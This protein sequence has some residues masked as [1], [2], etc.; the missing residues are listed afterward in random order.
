MGHIGWAV[1][2]GMNVQ[3]DLPVS[4]E[5]RTLVYTRVCLSICLEMNRRLN[6]SIPTP[7]VTPQS[8]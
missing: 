6:G 1:G 8:G 4:N 3:V 7:R 5:I 2:A